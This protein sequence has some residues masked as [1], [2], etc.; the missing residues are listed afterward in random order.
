MLRQHP[1]DRI[2]EVIAK[3]PIPRYAT[4]DDIANVFDFF[5][6][7]KSGYITGQTVYL[8]GVRN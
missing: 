8:G 5:T 7:D 3:L 2:D 6:S 4:F 1:R